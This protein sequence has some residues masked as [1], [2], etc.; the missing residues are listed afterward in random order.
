MLYSSQRRPRTAVSRWT[1]GEYC[2][3][4]APGLDP[5]PNGRPGAS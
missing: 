4:I 3:Q 2:A 1:P 5:G